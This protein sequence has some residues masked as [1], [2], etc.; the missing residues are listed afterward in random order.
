MK[1]ILILLSFIFILMLTPIIKTNASESEVSSTYTISADGEFIKTNEAYRTNQYN[2]DLGLVYP[3]DLYFDINDD[4]Y[5]VD[6]SYIDPFDAS[7]RGRIVIYDIVSKEIKSQLQHESF[8]S[9]SGIFV[10]EDL[11]IYVA[12]P[13]ASKIFIFDKNFNLLNEFSKPDSIAYDLDIF[14][15]KKIAVDKGGNIFVLVEGGYGGIIQLSDAGNFLGYFS[16][17]NVI[18]TNSELVRK[19]FYDLIGKDFNV[20]KTP[21][22]FSNLFVNN[23]SIVY[24]TTASSSPDGRIKKHNTQGIDILN[25]TL[26]SEQLSDIYVDS[27][28]IIYTSSATGVISVYS[29]YG[30]YIFHFGSGES[31]DG[32]IVGV[33]SDLISLA[34][35]STGEIFTID[36]EKS[37]LLSYEQTKYSEL[38]FQGLKLFDEGNYDES[39]RVWSEV[40]KYNQMAKLAY[41][42]L[43][44]TYIFKQDY[45]N[46]MK[47]FKLSKNREFY[48]QAYW[49][50]RNEQIKDTLPILFSSLLALGILYG[51]LRIVNHKTTYLKDKFASIKE[52]LNYKHIKEILYIKHIIRHPSDGFYQIR[53]GR[54]NGLVAPTF[55]M[56]LGFVSYVTFTTSKGFLFQ[57]VDIENINILSLVLGYFTLFAGFVFINYL[58]TSI[59]DGIAGIRKIFITTSYALVPYI[60]SIL[61]ATILSHFATLDESFF[62]EFIVLLGTLWSFLLLFLG[63]TII[64][65]YDANVTLKSFLFTLLLTIVTIIVVLFLQLMISNI[66]DFILNVI[67]EVIRLVL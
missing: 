22:T 30:D 53:K 54:I 50:V 32:D 40:L 67:L 9:P 59:T 41:D 11:D 31:L 10:S 58:V 63:S 13:G 35:S 57:V 6:S 21:P 28:G 47:Y 44:K 52:K 27:N 29:R 20:V 55:Y 1:K 36:Y 17:N 25:N 19:Y 39:T 64:Q 49:E 5:I 26:S 38:I 15:P 56:L 2:S 66:V 3:T 37:Y 33:Y 14:K 7:L 18:F 42:Q 48:S 51:V 60:I 45:E 12:D 24:S 16:S 34:V 8:V 65:N 61:I 43:G 23:D 46:A 4:L 62:V